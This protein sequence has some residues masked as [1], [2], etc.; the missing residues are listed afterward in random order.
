MDPLTPGLDGVVDL[1]V[2]TGPDVRPRKMTGLELARAARSAG[3][4]GF[5]LKNHHVPTV[6]AAYERSLTAR[7]SAIVQGSWS[8]SSLDGGSIAELEEELSELSGLTQEV[9]GRL[10]GAIGEIRAVLAR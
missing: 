3:M 10:D 1:H 9:E 6:I 8:Q 4:R 5:L 2:H 7:T